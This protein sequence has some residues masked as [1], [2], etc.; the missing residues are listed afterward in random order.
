M[1]GDDVRLC[2]F[3]EG[4]LGLVEG[5][6]VRDVTQALDAVPSYRYPLPSYDVLI[7]NLNKVAERV[8]ALAST[9]LVVSLE[10]LKL[11]RPVVNPCKIIAA[12]VNYQK[13]LDEV[14]GDAALHQ[15]TQAL[16][17]TIQKAG[18]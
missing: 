3:G 2:R 7:A 16:T 18:L 15:N 17:I 14:K 11:L 12:R 9:V 13:L 10:A 4:R 5:S 6:N 1:K 8:R